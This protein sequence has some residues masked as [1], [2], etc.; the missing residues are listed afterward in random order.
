MYP[1]ADKVILSFCSFPIEL[2]LEGLKE[3][4]LSLPEP[5]SICEYV[6]AS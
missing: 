3:D 5:I 1:P 6:E 4:E 2:H